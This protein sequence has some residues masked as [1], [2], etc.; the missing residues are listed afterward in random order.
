MS[1]RPRLLAAAAAALFF[2]LHAQAVPTL[3][4]QGNLFGALLDK[5]GLGYNR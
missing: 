1:F 5:S 2:T 3:I 4:A